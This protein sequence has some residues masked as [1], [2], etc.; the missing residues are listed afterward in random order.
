MTSPG[1]RFDK[2]Y[3][4]VLKLAAEKGEVVVPVDSLE[5]AKNLRSYFYHFRRELK[6]TKDPLFEQA[7][8]LKFF[9]DARALTVSR[10][11]PGSG[12]LEEALN[13]TS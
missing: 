8:D 13:A 9:A 7:K 5:E 4:E 6:E 1:R 2:N 10:K 12:A 3:Y 11:A